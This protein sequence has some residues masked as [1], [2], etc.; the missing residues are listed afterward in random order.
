MDFFFF[1]LNFQKYINWRGRMLYKEVLYIFIILHFRH[2]VIFG[3]DV[4]LLAIS[5]STPCESRHTVGGLRDCWSFATGR[6]SMEL[7]G[8][9]IRTSIRA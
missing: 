5:A 6:S 2:V 4:P 3:I 7:G 1:F 9:S 8:P